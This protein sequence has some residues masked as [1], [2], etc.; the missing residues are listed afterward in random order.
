MITTK[1][2]VRF[3]FPLSFFFPSTSPSHST[4]MSSINLN[5]EQTSA[6]NE[7]IGKI[8][9]RFRAK[10]S[11]GGIAIVEP[12]TRIG[13]THEAYV[14]VKI[15]T[16]ELKDLKTFTDIASKICHIEKRNLKFE[17]ENNSQGNFT[18][19]IDLP[20]PAQKK[21]VHEPIEKHGKFPTCCLLIA[22]LVV[23]FIIIFILI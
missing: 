8:C 23:I 3:F 2:A 14:R 7:M 6:I 10:S 4:K 18:Y 13:I 20:L 19:I 1:R 15:I 16:K 21:R 17:L 11:D 9:E 22:L 5:I 12:V